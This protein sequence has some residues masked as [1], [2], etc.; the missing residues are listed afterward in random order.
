MVIQVG[1]FLWDILRNDL[2][3]LNA[4]SEQNNSWTSV[5]TK[6]IH[7]LYRGFKS[8]NS[9]SRHI[10]SLHD[11]LQ[12]IRTFFIFYIFAFVCTIYTHILRHKQKLMSMMVR[13]RWKNTSKCTNWTLSIKWKQGDYLF[14][15]YQ[16]S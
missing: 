3:F 10:V 11:V 5:R 9:L 2:M 14:I 4:D 7:I 12:C 1:L 13:H 8:T 16:L 6:T 15:L